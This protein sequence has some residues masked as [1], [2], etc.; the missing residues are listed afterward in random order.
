MSIP[1]KD[2]PENESNACVLRAQI[3]KKQRKCFGVQVSVYLYDQ[4]E[5]CSKSAIND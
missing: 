4:W 1:P 5:D 3:K 2:E